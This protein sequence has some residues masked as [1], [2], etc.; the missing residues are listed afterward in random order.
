MVHWCSFMHTPSFSSVSRWP[1]L[2]PFHTRMLWIVKSILWIR[3]E[4]SWTPFKCGIGKWERNFHL[5]QEIMNS[6]TSFIRG[7][8]RQQGLGHVEKKKKK[9]EDNKKKMLF[10]HKGREERQQALVKLIPVWGQRMP[11]GS[12][13]ERHGRWGKGQQHRGW[14]EQVMEL[15][16]WPACLMVVCINNCKKHGPRQGGGEYLRPVKSSSLTPLFIYSSFIC[17]AIPCHQINLK[18]QS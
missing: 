11:S 15:D 2:L 17:L 13:W 3:T 12:Y 16:A 1:H 6:Q 10:N 8:R 18:C 9:K 7:H 14:P 4:G 5:P